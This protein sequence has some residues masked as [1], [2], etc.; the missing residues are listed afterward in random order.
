MRNERDPNTYPS[1]TFLIVSNASDKQWIAA[2]AIALSAPPNGDR[3]KNAANGIPFI[4]ERR[5]RFYGPALELT[6]KS[7]LR[8]AV[9]D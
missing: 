2:T 5:D 6:A 8:H 7:H 4:S 9:K 1:G 3:G